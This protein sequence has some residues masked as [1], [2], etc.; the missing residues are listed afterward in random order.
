MHALE[1]GVVPQGHIVIGGFEDQIVVGNGVAIFRGLH[2]FRG[3]LALVLGFVRLPG[4]VVL[5]ILLIFRVIGVQRFRVAAALQKPC[6]FRDQI[7]I[8]HRIELCPEDQGA[9]QA[10]AVEAIA[11][12]PFLHGHIAPGAVIRVVVVG[13][14][15]A[16]ASAGA[17]AVPIVLPGGIGGVIP[18]LLKPFLLLLELQLQLLHGKALLFQ[19]QI[20]QGCV[21]GQEQV[22][23]FHMVALFDLHAGNGLGIGEHDRLDIVRPDQT[24]GGLSVAPVVRHAADVEVV[25]INRLAAALGGSGKD[26]STNTSR[27]Q[28]GNTGNDPLFGNFKFHHRR[29]LPGSSAARRPE[30]DRPSLPAGQY[31]GRG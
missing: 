23:L 21:E 6:H 28:H 14:G 4:G 3:G 13:K 17:A 30:C 24:G 7:G 10:A 15:V 12:Q 26:S 16:L 22:A 11:V 25:D 18:D 5:L 9:V 8:H 2:R 29:L 20:R 1:H 27:C 31:G 19:G